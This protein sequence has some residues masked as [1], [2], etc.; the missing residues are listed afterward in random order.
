MFQQCRLLKAQLF[1]LSIL[2]WVPTGIAQI[3]PD[4]R[5]VE[6]AKK[7]AEV[8]WYTTLTLD[9]SKEVMDRF[10][11]K[12]PFIKPTLY[13]T[14]GGPLLN[15]ILSEARTG[16]RTWD[17]AVGPGLMVVP[18]M[19]RKLLATYRSPEASMIYDELA[20]KDGYWASFYALSFVLGYNTKLLKKED[21]P[22]TY[23]DLLQPKWKGSQISLDVEAYEM[24]QGL[25]AAWGK[26]KAISYFKRLAAQ[27]PIVQR[28]S[29]HRATLAAAGEFP[30]VMA[31]NQTCQRMIMRGA[32]ID[33]VPLEPAVVRVNPTVLAA[34]APHPNAAKLF[35]DFV[36][37]REGQ[38]MMQAFGGVPVRK[39]VEPD[40]PRLFRGY[41]WVIAHPRDYKNYEEIVKLYN[42][43]FSI[44]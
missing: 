13:R 31:F 16:G 9:M 39:D 24:L 11:K 25:M 26:S 37:S 30:L 2:V 20:D 32:P 7:E 33:W 14:A 15:R 43:I 12:Y 28:G 44:Q 10:H 19:E 21:L 1:V 4:P 35:I 3:A 27:Q 40:P 36:L 18:L 23:E 42:E 5:L 38:Q 29:T 17:V 8:I 6:A 34:N 22:K 41:K